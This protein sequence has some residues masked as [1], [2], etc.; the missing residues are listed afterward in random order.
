MSNPWPRGR[1]SADSLY[2]WAEEDWRA[3]EIAARKG[4]ALPRSALRLRAGARAACKR[5]RGERDEARGQ[6]ERLL[7]SSAALR[8]AGQISLEAAR[9][10]L[11]SGA[12]EILTYDEP[13]GAGDF[14]EL[15]TMC[16]EPVAE[17]HTWAG[18]V[19]K[20]AAHRDRLLGFAATLEHELAAA[21]RELAALEWLLIHHPDE[22]RALVMADGDKSGRYSYCARALGWEG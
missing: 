17:P 11:A 13:T 20:L 3:G 21:R 19:R 10:A 2:R 18:C 1:F 15:C 5:L 8:D 4:L 14:D 22:L 9:R 7:L 12:G 6:V 16:H